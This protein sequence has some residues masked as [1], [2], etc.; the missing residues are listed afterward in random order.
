[1]KVEDHL[2]SDRE[3]ARKYE[4]DSRWMA[5]WR[6]LDQL[7]TDQL[8]RL[9]N[10]LDRGGA[11]VCDSFN[12]DEERQLWCPLAVGLDVPRWLEGTGEPVAMTDELAKEIILRIGRRVCKNFSLN[13]LSGIRGQFFR[14][15]R[16]ADV[17]VVCR[18]LIRERQGGRPR[19]SRSF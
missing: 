10:R 3:V 5:L 18:L 13:P 14:E 1:M 11:I 19:L 16:Q 8:I 12:Y 17:A 4:S 7:R 2:P 9:L 6:G 15:R